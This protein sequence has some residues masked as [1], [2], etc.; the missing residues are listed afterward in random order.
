MRLA[1]YQSDRVARELDVN[2]FYCESDERLRP[3]VQTTKF[4]KR[5]RFTITMTLSK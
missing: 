2:I 1:G 3:F 5:N 4:I